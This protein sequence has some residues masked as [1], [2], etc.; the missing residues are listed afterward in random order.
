LDQ[1]PEA[2]RI[3]RISHQINPPSR[4]LTEEWIRFDSRAVLVWRFIDFGMLKT[5]QAVW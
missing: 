5:A 4:A 3:V 2:E 1:E